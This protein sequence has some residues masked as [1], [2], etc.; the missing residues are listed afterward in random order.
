MTTLTARHE[1]ITGADLTGSDGASN[2]QYGLGY[3]SAQVPQFQLIVA[4]SSLQMTV[5]YTLSSNTITF[6]NPVWDNQNITIDYYTSSGAVAAGTLTYATTLQFAAVIGVLKKIPSWDVGATPTIETVGTGDNSVTIFY[7]D[8]RNVLNNSYT[9]SYGASASS[10]TDLTEGTDYNIDLDSGKITLTA[11]GVTTVSTNNV[12]AEYS[13]SSID[14]SD[15]YYT[16]VLQRA[17]RRVNKE[18]S[19]VF[20]DG[21]ATNPD[22]P[23]LVEYQP[24]K[25]ATNLTYYAKEYPIIDITSE[26]DGDLTA[27]ATS[28]PLTAGDGSKFPSS[29]TIIIENEIITYTGIST[30]TLTGCT[31]GFNDSTATTHSDNADVH[32]TVVEI[33]GTAQGTSPTWYSLKHDSQVN[34]S[35]DSG[36]IFIYQ[37]NIISDVDLTNTVM[38]TPDVAQRF[39]ITYLHGWSTIPVDIT[40]LTILLA[41]NMLIT[42]SI[43]KSLIQGRNEFR[44]ELLNSDKDE[45]AS[46]IED[47]KSWKVSNT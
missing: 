5:D 37:D 31:R 26:I 34:I 32:S 36:K 14:L 46:I 28:I 11:T 47:Y 2:R 41:K 19:N 15:S 27:A 42:D 18:T 44:P 17:E 20:T 3:S 13:F 9:I 7:L 40:R 25:G 39:K 22:Y 6:L 24:S 16:T 8:Q 45:I 43:G 35:E 33:S 30:D 10:T 4:N 23:S 38:H 21:T 1:E 29:G 12:Y